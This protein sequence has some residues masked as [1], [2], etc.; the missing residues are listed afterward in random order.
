MH[1]VWSVAGETGVLLSFQGSVSEV[2]QENI[3]EILLGRIVSDDG[4]YVV[5]MDLHKYVFTLQ[6]GDRVEFTLSIDVPPYR[7]GIDFVGRATVVKVS[8]NE[9]LDPSEDKNWVHILSIGG[10]LVVIYSD[11]KLPIQPTQKLYVKVA[12]LKR[13]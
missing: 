10:L 5:K 13:S 8:E 4:K 12:P 2:V 1:T 3:P 11:E 6:E 7:E 9:G